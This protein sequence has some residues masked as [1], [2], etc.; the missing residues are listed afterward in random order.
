LNQ[1][2]QIFFRKYFANGSALANELKVFDASAVYNYLLNPAK[3][4]KKVANLID[5]DIRITIIGFSKILG[6]YRCLGSELQVYD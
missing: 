6:Q 5:L 1:G 2:S 4:T 3:R